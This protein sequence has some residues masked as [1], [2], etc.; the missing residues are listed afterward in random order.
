[1]D[2]HTEQPDP[3]VP[4]WVIVNS[5]TNEVVG[6]RPTKDEADD[7]ADDLFNEPEVIQPG[8]VACEQCEQASPESEMEHCEG[9][10]WEMCE[11]CFTGDECREEDDD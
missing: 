8:Y 3:T 7:Y 6:T 11:D 5:D 1:M 4:I 2:Y 10:G 9:C